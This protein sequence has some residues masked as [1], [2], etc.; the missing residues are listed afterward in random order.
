MVSRIPRNTK[1]KA[2]PAIRYEAVK[3]DA[4][5]EVLDAVAWLPNPSPKEIAQ[6]DA[7]GKKI[8]YRT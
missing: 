8:R 4:L 5:F 1:K 2:P 7:G 3:L 6:F